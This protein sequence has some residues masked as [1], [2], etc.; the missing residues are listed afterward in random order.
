MTPITSHTRMKDMI[1]MTVMKIIWL[2][3]VASASAVIWLE[4]TLATPEP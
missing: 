3:N 4:S 1:E 2:V